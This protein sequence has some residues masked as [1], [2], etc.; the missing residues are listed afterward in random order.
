VG[1]GTPFPW[2]RALAAGVILLALT[3]VAIWMWRRERAVLAGW[4][5]F[6]GMLVPTIGLVQV[7]GQAL[8][9]RYTYLPHIGLFI[10]IVWGVASL[11]EYRP[12]LR[13]TLEGV[14]ALAVTALIAAT[15]WQLPAW[16][17][18]ETLFLRAAAVTQRNARAHVCLAL[19]YTDTGQ[20]ERARRHYQL[21]LEYHPSESEA[22][23][24]YG[25][26][27]AEDGKPQEAIQHIEMAI[28]AQPR[29]A[30]AHNNLANLLVARGD[31]A[32][33]LRHYERSIA[34]DPEDPKSHFNYGLTLANSGR[35][36][37]AQV[38]LERA[39]QL[40]GDYPE[41]RYTYGIVQAGLGYEAAA[42]AQLR[43]ANFLRPDWYDALRSLAWLLAT[44]PEQKVRNGAQAVVV[45]ERANQVTGYENP[46]ALDT[47]AAAYAEAGR[48]DSAVATESRAQEMARA[49]GKDAL[50]DRFAARLEL[51]RAGKP[52]HRV[53]GATTQPFDP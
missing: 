17:N 41:A 49:A 38:Q 23:N 7:G 36:R 27:L 33:A 34:L 10:A 53:L 28:R 8:A 12:A 26:M 13:R 3:A 47:L 21:A 37:D 44:S 51:Y 1:L 43:D 29:Y 48:F 35:L 18:T 6:L 30:Q 31:V 24:N 22:N 2:S 4:L 15:L 11:A 52:F 50:A 20:R 14:A 16:R 45:A 25:N 46:I 9:D 5:W 32:G 19:Y 39:L 42:T 40:Q